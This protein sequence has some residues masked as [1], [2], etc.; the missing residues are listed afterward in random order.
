MPDQ[1]VTDAEKKLDVLYDLRRGELMIRFFSAAQ[2]QHYQAR[3]HE[4]RILAVDEAC[5]WLP[6]PSEVTT[7]RASYYGF[8][9][10]FEDIKMAESW[11][12]RSLI[13][14]LHPRFENPGVYLK[15]EWVE[16]ELNELLG[17]NQSQRLSPSGQRYNGH[18]LPN[19]Q[20]N[21]SPQWGWPA[22]TIPRFTGFGVSPARVAADNGYSHSPDA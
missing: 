4:A 16:A 18:H 19:I 8:T 10:H 20:G 1:G 15:R 3:N 13:G 5:V 22:P 14:R 7:L 2:A 17:M 11:R 12:G 9:L 6:L 21:S